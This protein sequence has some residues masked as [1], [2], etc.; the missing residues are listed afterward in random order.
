MERKKP[1]AEP[2]PCAQ[3]DLGVRF[4]EFLDGELNPE[5]AKE[6]E[7]HLQVCPKCRRELRLWASLSEEGLPSSKSSLRAK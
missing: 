4:P 7:R 6:I 1:S 5:E 2:I 3:P